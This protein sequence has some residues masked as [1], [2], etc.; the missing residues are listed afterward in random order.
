MTF[1]STSLLY[2]YNRSFNSS[3]NFTWNVTCNGSAQGYDVLN[4]VDTVIIATN[5]S[6]S[7]ILNN[8]P[9]NS[10]TANNYVL[11]NATVTDKDNDT[12]V[13]YFYGSYNPN[14][15]FTLLNTTSNVINGST[16]VFNWTSFEYLYDP[17]M[18]LWMHFNNDSSV[19]ENS[20]HVY[21]FS[22]NGNNGTVNG[23]RWTSEGKFGGAFEFNNTGDRIE[24]PDSPSWDLPGD[25]Q[26]LTIM[27]WIYIKEP[28]GNKW[29]LIFC[30]NSD[31]YCFALRDDGGNNYRPEWWT[32]TDN[33]GSSISLSNKTWYHIAVVVDDGN[34]S[35][36]FNGK[37]NSS[38]SYSQS[39]K[40][41]TGA[42]IGGYGDSNLFKG[43]L[44]E[45]AIYNR[46]LSATEILNHYRLGEG[47]YYWK[48]NASDGLLSNESEVWEF[49]IDKTEPT[50]P[51]LLE[52]Y[53]NTVSIDSTPELNWN[54]V[55]EENFANYTIEVS[56]N[57]SFSYVNYTYNTLNKTES[58]Y[59]VISPWTTDTKWY[60]R[61]TA[62]DKA[63]NSN[64]SGIFSYIIDT[65]KPLIT[66]PIPTPGAFLSNISAVLFQVNLTEMNVNLSI[67]V[68]LFYRKQGIGNYKN[69]TLICYGNAPDYVCNKTIDLSSLVMDGDIIEYFFN[70]TDLAGLKGE[71]GN[72]THPL[73]ATV[74]TTPPSNPSNVSFVPDPTPYFDNDG[75]L[76]VNWSPA[77]DTNGIKE[78]RIYVSVNSGPYIYNGTNTSSLQYIFNGSDGKNYSVNV[79]AVDNAGNE[80]LSGCVS[81]TTITVDTTKPIVK[82]TT[83]TEENDTYWSRDW[84]YINVS[85]TEQNEEN[86]TFYLYNSTGLVNSTTYTNGTHWINFTNLSDGVYW[87]NVTVYD[88][89]GNYN[90]TETRKQTLITNESIIFVPP[91]E[92]ND[93]YWSR[94]WIYVKVAVFVLNESNITFY[95]YN[96]TGLVN[97]TTY[98]N[99]THWINF[100]NLSDGVYWF[101]VT[102]YDKAGN[103]NSTETRKQTLD[104]T[105]PTKPVLFEPPDG[106]ESTDST[107]ELNWSSVI[108]EN[109][110]NYTIEVDD[111]YSFDTLDYVY[112][113]SSINESNYS[114]ISPWNEGVWFWRVIA[115]DKAGNYNISDYF[116][117]RII[118]VYPKIN[119]SGPSGYQNNPDINLTVITDRNAYCR[120]DYSDRT[121]M[122]MRYHFANTD[123]INHSTPSNAIEGSNIY[124]VRCA[125]DVNGTNSMIFSVIITFIL[126]TEKPEISIIAPD[127]NSRTNDKR[128]SFCLTDS[129]SGINRSKI[130]VELNG[131]NSNYFDISNC[132]ENG[133]NGYDCI[134]KEENISGGTNNIS[135]GVV[136]NADN[137]LIRIVKF[138]YD[139]TSPY[140][141]GIIVNN[142]PNYNTSKVILNISVPLDTYR[143][144]YI[145]DR[146]GND[147]TTYD[148]MSH[149]MSKTNST[150]YTAS[151]IADIGNNTYFIRC[152]DLAG[153]KDNASTVISFNVKVTEK[154]VGAP[155]ITIGGVEEDYKPGSI[156]T[157][158]VSILDENGNPIN[159]SYCRI[160]IRHWNGSNLIYDVINDTMTL[161]ETGLYYYNYQ[162]P[163][164]AESGSY[165]IIVEANPSGIDTHAVSGF[166]VI[167]VTVCGN[168]VCESG[169]GCENCPEDCGVCSFNVTVCG[170]G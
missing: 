3:G 145:S 51:V 157:V 14:V 105:P 114:V 18:V 162:I 6:P 42:R 89:V 34:A 122:N 50:K 136:D 137:S 41:P 115:Y 83:P 153:N 166:H 164:N 104:T 22:G 4:A 88:K 13:V 19:G 11:L 124:Y 20:T 38:V 24:I 70:T 147:L 62:Y 107:P 26:S 58:N 111:D 131:Y 36:Y 154:K 99:G 16:V 2:E 68:T 8:P 59:S 65:T 76:V 152:M 134:Y 46:T 55:I 29:Y 156:V 161:F 84:I 94:D 133:L 93:T 143:C 128:V 98:T 80:N 167:N 10:V 57:R 53:N 49:I 140:Y 132:T 86:I 109:F 142:K 67:N 25:N 170:N 61:V 163:V 168:G 159:P 138:I 127:N 43:F 21:D 103:Y 126:D 169:E 48:V 91:T 90:S 112:I 81:S 123:G 160:T 54:S 165:G 95:L 135:V 148:E 144:K 101:N 129:T 15:G 130:S 32:G 113:T 30:T 116:S 151:I 7:I 52:P 64:T 5:N 56:T 47:K 33:Y 119:R 97:S 77:S 71:Y 28:L 44:D 9:N 121:F 23:T 158:F 73:I 125:E 37:L 120:Y 110:A 17:S 155:S 108:E 45:I 66:S 31:E 141:D 82:F 60:W 149:L 87:F 74:D 139:D 150:V 75:I 27:A 78:Y 79:T 100:T 96:S 40:S 69:D 35:F 106:T 85:V 146:E 118:S 1:N 63:G 117:Y 102:V 92:E 72:K 12:M 39:A